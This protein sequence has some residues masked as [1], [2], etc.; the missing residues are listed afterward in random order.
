MSQY[1][2]FL[3]FVTKFNFRVK[4]P[5]IFCPDPRRLL[6]NFGVVISFGGLLFHFQ[7]FHQAHCTVY[8]LLDA[9]LIKPGGFTRLK[10]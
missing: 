6:I 7:I 1:L 8:A 9:Q 3:D 5:G 2:L 10:H 4:K